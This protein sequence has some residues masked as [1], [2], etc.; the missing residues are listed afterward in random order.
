MVVSL[1][2]AAGGAAALA[3]GAKALLGAGR[4]LLA[5]LGVL[6]LYAGG[7]LLLTLVLRVPEARE[8]A[9]R[10]RRRARVAGE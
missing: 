6:G 9:E 5:G 4:P 10:L 1:W 3:F 7:Y 8:V 2:C